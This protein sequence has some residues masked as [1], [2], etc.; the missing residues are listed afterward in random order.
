MKKAL[1]LISLASVLFGCNKEIPQEPQAEEH[2]TLDFSIQDGE[3]PDTKTIK[4][5]WSN[6]D[7]IYIFFDGEITEN[8]EYLVIK[9]DKGA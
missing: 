2:V 6:N 5:S 7:R 4:K 9:Y 8:P 3:S 1:F